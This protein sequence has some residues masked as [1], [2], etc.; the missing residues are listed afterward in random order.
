M[1]KLAL[2]VLATA[3]VAIAPSC[4][5]QNKKQAAQE[6]AKTEISDKERYITEDL[7]INLGNLLESVSKMK[8]V[9]FISGSNGE[10]V[11]SEQEKMVKPA[12]LLDP[13][14]TDN[15]V[16]LVQKYRAVSML[17]IDKVVAEMYG[18]PVAEYEAAIAK[19]N[20]EINDP[21]LKDFIEN[22]KANVDAGEN[23]KAFC[24]AEISATRAN[25]FWEAVSAAL[26]EQ[27]YVLTQNIEKFM[28]MFDD[29]SASDVTYDF[30]TVHEGILS[31]IEFYPEMESLNTI[32][33][34]LYVIN[35]INVDQ[36]RSQLEEL[37]GDIENVRAQL[38]K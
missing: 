20:V 14:E 4:K 32:L 38:L 11:L 12:Y 24:D 36:L 23:I 27:V 2:L 6:Q 16:T 19:L 13:K 22:T 28:P 15:A 8:N 29:Q 25:F 5:N 10:V 26:V 21:A 7:K 34:P 18:M 3:I 31:L 35:A 33:G 17:A 1:K 9:P 37:K 30:I